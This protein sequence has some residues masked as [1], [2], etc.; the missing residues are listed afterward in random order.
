MQ[1]SKEAF[2]KWYFG[3]KAKTISD[4][5]MSTEILKRVCRNDASMFDIINQHLEDAFNAGRKS[6][7]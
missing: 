6:R 4:M 1:P 5:P 3:A 7:D 2:D